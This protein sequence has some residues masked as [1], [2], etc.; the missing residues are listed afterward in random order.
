MVTTHMSYTLVLKFWYKS[1]CMQYYYPYKKCETHDWIMRNKHVKPGFFQEVNWDLLA[2]N[3]GHNGLLRPQILFFFFLKKKKRKKREISP[4][5]SSCSSSLPRIQSSPFSPT[6]TIFF[7]GG[8]SSNKSP[9]A[10]SS[11]LVSLLC[12]ISLSLSPPLKSLSS[13]F[14]SLPSHCNWRH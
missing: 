6:S 5:T 9:M 14:F 1:W 12:Q 10:H 2:F 4:K 11:L 3:E 13:P 8:S 7:S